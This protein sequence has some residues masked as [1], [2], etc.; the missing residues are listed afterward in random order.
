MPF[1]FLIALRIKELHN[2]KKKVKLTRIFTL[3]GQRKLHIFYRGGSNHQLVGGI[4]A[5]SQK[6]TDIS[7]IQVII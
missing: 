4:G 2:Q 6:A 3:F 7:G 5:C 1:S